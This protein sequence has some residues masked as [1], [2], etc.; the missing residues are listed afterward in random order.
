MGA[1]SIAP[2]GR[3]GHIRTA[4]GR[5]LLA[6]LL[7]CLVALTTGAGVAAAQAPATASGSEAG[8]TFWQGVAGS[9][10]PA[11]DDPAHTSVVEGSVVGWRYRSAEPP[12][13]P[14]R[15]AE[16]CDGGLKSGTSWS[17][18]VQVAVIVDVEPGD[19]PAGQPVPESLTRCVGV[20]QLSDAAA[21]L[22]AARLQA[23]REGEIRG[24]AAER[25][26][27]GLPTE[28]AVDA[29]TPLSG[30]AA[31]GSAGLPPWWPWLAALAVLAVVGWALAFRP[32]RRHRV[33]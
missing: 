7:A 31:G 14:A 22:T 12:A 30:G 6:A 26:I 1:R 11:A 27:L 23:I 17:T 18:A 3:D 15:F 29:S 16:L 24:S 20:P 25:T 2:P 8:W 4:S 13:S 21:A 19:V 28:G 9:W 10:E 33:P 5:G 32:L